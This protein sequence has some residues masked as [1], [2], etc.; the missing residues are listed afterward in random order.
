[1]LGERGGLRVCVSSYGRARRRMQGVLS[2]PQVS[3]HTQTGLFHP[4]ST[5][6]STPECLVTIS[7]T[8]AVLLGFFGGHVGK[9]PGRCLSQCCSIVFLG[10]LGQDFVQH[11]AGPTQDLRRPGSQY[12]TYLS[13]NAA[14]RADASS[15]VAWGRGVTLALWCR[16]P[17]A[18]AA[19]LAAWPTQYVAT[20]QLS[21]CIVRR[22]WRVWR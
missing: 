9:S 1:M 21:V 20:G 4:S 15:R 13:A 12:R 6:S 10:V 19:P 14:R 3:C 5:S 18:S 16:P 17:G 2:H 11:A 22:K 8:S 7:S